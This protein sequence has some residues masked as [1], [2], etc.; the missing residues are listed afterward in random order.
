M[1]RKIILLTTTLILS[2]NHIG[3]AQRYEF[4]PLATKAYKNV[5][6]L[7]FADAYKNLAQMRLTEADNLMYYYIA[8]YIDVM[9]VFLNENKAEFV[10]LEKNKERRIEALATGP[11]D[12]PY[13]LL[14]QAEVNIHWALVRAKT[15]KYSEYLT[16]IKEISNAYKMLEKNTKKFPD[17]MPNKKCLSVMHAAIGTVP[18]EF[19]W[20]L[21]MLNIEGSL[22]QGRKELNEL[23]EYSQKNKFIFDDEVH[24]IYTFTL[25]YLNNQSEQAWEIVKKSHL[26][27]DKNPLAALGMANVAI[28][29]GHIDEAVH[30]LTIAPRTKAYHSLPYLDYYM[31]M[32]KLFRFDADANIYLKRYIDF[33]PGKMGIK[34][35][36]QK[37]AWHCL[38]N[39]DENGYWQNMAAVKK[40][41]T[42]MFEGD[43]AAMREAKSGIKQD[44]H[45][46][47]VRI[48]FDGS[49]FLK[50]L[51]EIQKK[52][53]EDYQYDEK[54]KLEYMYRLGRIYHKLGRSGEAIIA[55]E[56]TVTTGKNNPAYF[57]CNAALQIGT[58]YEE[59]GIY[60]KAK[61][62]YNLCLSIDP[63]DYALSLHQRAKAG[64]N[65]CK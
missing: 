19:K 26:K 55:Y 25:L 13:Y 64:L 15:G 63:E 6:S 53:V 56:Q 37:L 14:T 50:A 21:N 36:Y 4:T 23:V 2:L 40:N 41:G 65:R 46:L 49:Q 12:S 30:Y 11:K 52:R 32:A 62:Y 5:I 20:G 8:D 51:E 45:L 9:K 33:H 35:S 34:E 29:T 54:L 3:V 10:K 42:D 17:F 57:A 47:K 22:E 60:Q 24:C 58:I 7:R 38:I 27:P 16:A 1:Y 48:L 31:G 39:G 59:Q 44:A 28:K 61:D 43:K 18:N